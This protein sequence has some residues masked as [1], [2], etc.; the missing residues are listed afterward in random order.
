MATL[1]GNKIKNTYQS[2]V[3]FSDNGNITTTAKQLTDGFGNNSPMFVS[4]TQIGIGVTPETG[5]NLHVFGDAKIGSNL[6]VIGNLVVEGSTTTVGTDTLTVKDPLIVLANNNT[7]SDAVDIGFY[8]KYHPSNTTLYSGLFREALTG[9]YRL[10]KGLQVEPTTTVNTSGTGYAVASLVANLEGN[11]IGGTISG[12]TGTFSGNIIV[13]GTVDGRDVA[14]DGAKL[15][16]IEAGAT[17]DQTAAEIKTAYESNSNTNAFT[18]ADKTKLDGI[19]ASADVTDA[20]NVLAAGAVMT[21]GNQ[22]ISGVKTFSDQVTIPATPSA[23][24]D[25]ASKGYV[26]SAIGDNNELSEVLANGNTTGGTDIDVSAG[27]DITFADS[28]KS[29]Y[30]DDFDL[31]IYHDN[32]KGI[33]RNTTGSLDIQSVEFLVEDTSGNNW[34]KTA[35]GGGVLLY[36]NDSKKFE[37]TSYGI[38][39]TG[40]ISIPVSNKILFGGSSHTYISEDID[41]RLRFFVGGA[42][43][44]RFTEGVSDTINFYQDVTFS[45]DLIVPEYI[46]HEGDADTSI[47]FTTN[48]IRFYTAN[49]EV[50]ELESDGQV[51]VIS[52]GTATNPC[53]TIGDDVNTGIWRPALDTF[54]ISTA[55]T[56]RMR[57]NSS[58]NATFAGTLSS[59]AITSTGEIEGGSLDINGNADITGNLNILGSTALNVTGNADD[60]W[61][62]RFENTNS[63]GFGILAQIAGTSSN[64]RI[65]EARVGS[66][67]KMLITGDGNTTFAGNVK[68]NST[69]AFSVGTVGN[70]GNTA[71]DINIYSTSSGHNGLRMHANGILPTDNA[72]TIIDNDADLGFPTYRFKD[73]YLGGSITAGGATFAGSVTVDG[74]SNSNV[75]QLALTRTDFSW[76]IFNETDLRFYVQSGNTTT[77]NTQVLQIGTTGLT[78]I[79]RTGITGVAK[80]D[81]ILQIGYEGNNGQNNLIGFGYNA[82]TN[83]PAYIGYTTTSG[84][85][86]TKGDLV[87]GTR[88]VTSDTAPSERMRI[89]SGGDI[90]FTGN[91]HTPYI[92]LVNSGRTEGNP[93]FTFNGD[94]NT[95]MFQPAGVA[96]T[97]A[98]STG[99]SERMRITSGGN[100]GIGTDDPD[101]TLHLLKSSGDT[102]MYINGQ[103]GQSSLRM[104]L[105]LRNWQIK[106]AAAPY[107]WS[108][109]YVGT[110]FQTPNI[111][112]ATVG[113]NV[114]IGVTSPTTTLDARGSG[115][116]SNPATSGTT[117]STGT[118]FRLGSSTNA[119]AVLDFGIS[120]GGKSWLQATDKSDLSTGYNFLI[121]PNGGN[122]GI[123]TTS[124]QRP[125]HVNGTEGVARFTSTASGNNGFEVGI[126]TSSQAFLWQS[127]NAHMEF[128]TNNVERMRITSTG[129]IFMYGLGGYTSSN[130]DVRYATSSKE[131]YYQTSSKRYKTNIVNLENSLDKIDSLRP[132]RYVDINTKEPACGLI[133]EETVEIIPEVVFTKEIEGFDEPQVEGINYSDLVPFLIKSIQEL[134]AEVELLKTQI[135][136]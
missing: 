88:S 7:A 106:T 13:S 75:S 42:E 95:G 111:L 97:I 58:G 19:E 109:N 50:L 127:E 35:V 83:I 98:F 41:D 32:S 61:I 129:T 80:A 118:R 44:M 60:N 67:T 57:I 112:T 62:G 73:L 87:F 11:F 68:S 131:L 18:D 114:G 120:T 78:T 31:K 43:F 85:G 24:T 91:S 1:S 16:G 116:T 21:T 108:L 34:I 38:N 117:V 102:E 90:Q 124:P 76:G 55:G 6:T 105:D 99:G 26:D 40:D 52:S 89:T 101:Y 100:V 27:D 8:G 9:K 119:T 104:G 4:T 113:G 71:G 30:G 47:R 23:S 45:G 39:V 69:T 126:G 15:D 82:Q 14:T 86:S 135:N 33:I 79:K 17:T 56:E 103:N 51:N 25:A 3:K 96:D 63:G 65:F 81:M 48:T 74:A 130:A 70:I 59:G 136:N 134:K 107:L 94:T 122:V 54:A 2:L 20:T 37:T 132:V 10:F 5:L 121:N 123:G 12:T 92:Q 22:S 77:P 133:A 29:I 36:Y 72:G 64:E 93:G 128:A 84:S 110:D 46:K 125:L 49:N 115:A 66:S 28:S 53:I